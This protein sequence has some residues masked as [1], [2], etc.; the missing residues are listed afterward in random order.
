MAPKRKSDAL[1]N[2]LAKKPA[3]ASSLSTSAAPSTALPVL[4]TLG[5]AASKPRREPQYLKRVIGGVPPLSDSEDGDSEEEPPKKKAAASG[6]KKEKKVRTPRVPK[7]KPTPKEP[8]EN[9]QSWQDI[10]LDDE[11][12]RGWCS[13]FSLEL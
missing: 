11:Y 13:A 1:A 8:V 4:T 9:P 5:Q 2:P 12:V 3:L 10:V 7:P 6:E